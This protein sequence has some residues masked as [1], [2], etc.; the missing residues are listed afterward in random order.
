[1]LAIAGSAK[2]TKPT[3]KRATC[4]QRRVVRTLVRSSALYHITSVIRLTTPPSRPK[5]KIRTTATP[6]RSPQRGGLPA[7]H[8]PGIF[9]PCGVIAARQIREDILVEHREAAWRR[10][11][12]RRH[13]LSRLSGLVGLGRALWGELLIIEAGLRRRGARFVLQRVDHFPVGF[14]VLG[15]A[16]AQ[17]AHDGRCP[18]SRVRLGKTGFEHGAHVAAFGRFQRPGLVLGRKGSDHVGD[19]RNGAN[20]LAENLGLFLV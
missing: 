14:V 7:P 20:D 4:D 1:M 3:T 15:N 10:Y 16:I 11:R 19:L 18:F 12:A 2:A 6:I 9:F 17:S 5:T 13:I 8:E